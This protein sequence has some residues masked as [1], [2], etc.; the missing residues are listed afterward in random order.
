MRDGVSR[1][2]AK[3]QLLLNYGADVSFENGEGDYYS[4]LIFN[5]FQLETHKSGLKK[6]G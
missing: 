1:D 4:Q 6:L 2:E 5:S 3:A